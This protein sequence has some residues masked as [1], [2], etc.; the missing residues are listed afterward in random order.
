MITRVPWTQFLQLVPVSQRFNCAS[1]AEPKGVCVFLRLLRTF[2]TICPHLRTTHPH[3]D[4]DSC[5]VTSRQSPNVYS[6]I[7]KRPCKGFVDWFVIIAA[8]ERVF[9]WFYE[10]GA[11]EPGGVGVR[12]RTYW[13]YRFLEFVLILAQYTVLLLSASWGLQPLTKTTSPV[14][15]R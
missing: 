5:N 15:V 9:S 2:T 6:S 13:L 3:F 1:E 14:V 10:Y 8:A 7:C 4:V 11:L 12:V